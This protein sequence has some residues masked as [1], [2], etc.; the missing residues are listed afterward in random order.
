[1][2]KGCG[3]YGYLLAVLAGLVLGLAGLLT[4]GWFW[5]AG[6]VL[7]PAPAVLTQKDWSAKDEAALAL[8]IAPVA[9]AIEGRESKD[10]SFSLTPAEANRL[11]QEY[12]RRQ[13]WGLSGELLTDEGAF[14]VRF[15]E[16]VK[17]GRYL[18][19]ELR[20]EVSA[21]GGKFTAKA[22]SFQ[23]GNWKLP[24]GFLAELGYW[25]AGALTT[26]KPF[27]REPWRL[28]A[29]GRSNG[30]ITVEVRTVVKK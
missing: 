6:K 25:I 24:P 16:R 8:K 15:S 22:L 12:L 14:K 28:L 30:A 20:A 26:Q 5:A 18:N 13:G 3:C 23:A 19:G 2:R 1:M 11:F 9:K 21:S 29:L 4:A 7:S 17:Q 10:F 27:Q